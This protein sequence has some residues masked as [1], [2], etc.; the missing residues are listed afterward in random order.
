[1]RVIRMALA[2]AVAGATAVAGPAAGSMAGSA[3]RA[4]PARA[5]HLAAEAV[6]ATCT[7][8]DVLSQMSLP[9]RVGQLFMTG[10]DTDS[11]TAAQL[12]MIRRRHL[13]GV[14]L[15]G[16]SFRGVAA[17]RAT[18]RTIQDQARS[19]GVGLWV[20]A[21]QEGGE[22]QV[23]NGPGFSRIPTALTQGSWAPSTLQARARTWGTQLAAAG[24]NLN[25]APVLDTVPAWLGTGNGPI[26]RYYREYGYRPAVV[27]SHGL[28]VRRGMRAAN[29]QT[30][31]KH[32]PG[33]GR[34][35]NNTDTSFDVVDDV[36]TRHDAYLRPFA[37]AIA[38][39]I[40][41]VMVSSARYTRIDAKHLAMFSPVVLRGML[42]HDLGFNGVIV[43]D[44]L[45]AAAVGHVPVQWRAV[46]LLRAGGDVALTADS[47]EVPAMVRAVLQRARQVPDFRARVD[48]AAL[49]VLRAKAREALLPCQ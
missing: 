46:R 43:S 49:T 40:P 23:L 29:V 42:R 32:F 6:P 41:V 15:I 26:G 31:A 22:V 47:A 25:L 35:R 45:S 20:S 38:H 19:D 30:T 39:G 2:A 16:H 14:V 3:A 34:V 8:A 9:Q 7:P 13:G 27:T 1:M 18:T 11:P 12:Q 44:S 48:A 21:D 5:D 4:Y 28:A 24:V 17:M 36:T 10:V 37:A 33:L